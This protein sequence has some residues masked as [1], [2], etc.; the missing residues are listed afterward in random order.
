MKK[1]TFFNKNRKIFAFL[2]ISLLMITG[3][4]AWGQ[5]TIMSDACSSATTGWTFTNT[6]TT[7]AI[8]QNNY[9]LI[10]ASPSDVIISATI[11]VSNYSN[12]VLTCEVATYGTGNNNS[13]KIEYSLNNGTTWE[14]TS[15]TTATPSSSTYIG[16][17]NI[18]L[19]TLNTATLKLK[20]TNNGAT[21]QGV[22]MRNILLTGTS[23]CTTPSTVTLIDRGVTIDVLEQGVCTDAL[24][25]PSRPSPCVGWTFEGWK[26]GSALSSDV[27][28]R[29]DLKNGSYTPANNITLYAV[30]S[31]A[32][33]GNGTIILTPTSITNGGATLGNNAYGGGAERL[34]TQDDISF[35]GKAITNAPAGTN[36][37]T[38]QC[39][40][41]NGIIYNISAL[42]G[43]ILSITIDAT[44]GNWTCTGG[45][46][47][48][49]ANATANDYTQSGTTVGSAGLSWTFTGVNYTFFAI[50][51]TTT[52]SAYANSITI[53]YES[54]SYTYSTATDCVTCTTTPTLGGT[55]PSS[56]TVN[57]VTLSS[58]FTNTYD[59]TVTEYGF[60]YSKTAATPTIADTKKT[61]T[62]LSSGSFSATA[63]GLDCGTTYNVCSY[64]I[65]DTSDFAY[66][67]TGTFTTSACIYNVTLDPGTLGYVP[68]TSFPNTTIV[69]NLPTPTLPPTCSGWTFE[70]W[71]ESS[72]PINTTTAPT[73]L[74]L[75]GQSFTPTGQNTNITLYAVYSKTTGSN[76]TLTITR[77]NFEPG[78]LAYESTNNNDGDFWVATTTGGDVVT[79]YF[80]IY[81]TVNQTNMQTNTSRGT[82]P[83]N[84]FPLPGA[85][86]KITLTEGGTG[87][88]RAWTPYL[89]TTLLTKANY[90]TGTSQGVK[91]ASSNT[92]SSEWIVNANNR[93]T[94]FY[95]NMT[96]GAAYLNSIVIDY[97]SYTSY[98]TNTDCCTTTSAT[99]TAGTP[100]IDSENITW[101]WNI[102]E[103]AIGY[104]YSK[105]DDYSTATTTLNTFYKELGLPGNSQQKLYVWAYNNCGKSDSIILNAT[106]NCKTRT[107]TISPSVPSE[108]IVLNTI[109]KTY[110]R[111]ATTTGTGTIYWTIDNTNN[112]TATVRDSVPSDGSGGM[113]GIV[114]FD[115]YGPIVLTAHINADGEYCAA[116][117]KSYTINIVC[118]NDAFALTST[119]IEKPFN[120]GTFTR[121]V[122]NVH[123]SSP[124]TYSS[125]NNNIAI[126][127]ANTGVVTFVSAGTVTITASCAFSFPYCVKNISYDLTITCA[128]PTNYSLSNVNTSGATVS[129]TGTG[130]FLVEYKKSTEANYSTWATTSSNSVNFTGLDSGTTYDIRITQ[131]CGTGSSTELTSSFKTNSNVTLN[132]GSGYVEQT[133]YLNVSSVNLQIPDIDCG[134]WEFAGWATEEN[135]SNFVSN[136]YTPTG[137]ITLYAVYKKTEGD[138]FYDLVTSNSQIGEGIYLIGTLYNSAYW[139]FNGTINGNQEGTANADGACTS[140]A[141]NNTTLT[142]LPN[143][144]MEMLFVSTGTI[145]QYYVKNGSNYLGTASATNR[146]VTFGTA[147][148]TAWNVTYSTNL[149]MK[150]S[151]FT[152]WL[153]AYNGELRNYN[154]D[155]TNDD[156]VLFKKD[157]KTTT[158]YS[159][160]PCFTVLEGD[161][162]IEHE[163]I[164]NMYVNLK[165]AT[166]AQKVYTIEFALPVEGDLIN[167]LGAAFSCPTCVPQSNAPGIMFITPQSQYHTV[168]FTPPSVGNYSATLTLTA[169]DAD[170]FVIYF[171]GTAEE[172]STGC[173]TPQ[174]V[175]TIYTQGNTLVVN[176]LAGETI[177]VYNVLGQP[178]ARLTAQGSETRITVPSGI[179]LVRIADTTA[180]VVVK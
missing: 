68:Q 129:W 85:I 71:K 75:A 119:P 74:I 170:N 37:G 103:G 11:N 48:R 38:L 173:E 123:T 22:R 132:A 43:K 17:G 49:L 125:S 64:A 58:A 19:G 91:T 151:A 115:D 76:G 166:S 161:T 18:N 148:K 47:G 92:A 81:S 25:L 16:S 78:A 169:N 3:G 27:S 59:C 41:S 118:S 180:K 28:V 29:P 101:R 147:H 153:R 77:S 179:L 31:K 141:N 50:K 164:V 88:A 175:R 174:I 56:Q 15:F 124:I 143:G 112:P 136:T 99:P 46:T 84:D 69:N 54:V 10:D 142:G 171:V 120:E 140:S 128:A 42:K 149:S 178:L 138:I 53:N 93:F 172:V 90:T 73:G 83:Y 65:Y 33:V 162:K 12:L 9:W 30:Y 135:A 157:D 165:V 21:G 154:S 14:T 145:G 35:G 163:D 121:Q 111:K 95:L 102:V 2:I 20:F 126:V 110:F 44:G 87:T 152:T 177:E 79:G 96:G 116:A 113:V 80:D 127:D 114:T 55:T 57:S 176:T 98:S 144:A 117:D 62:N 139:F 66:G 4:K 156:I 133:E 159:T 1:L 36:Q 26:E 63:T 131:A 32:T 97:S 137:N 108:D 94:Y 8:Q 167:T 5:T 61:S 134:E 40:A 67:A 51:K 146:R 24:T 104:K 160:Y 100:I 106:T 45:N 158:T 7:N 23:T 109:P 107:I 72:A 105:T 82:F 130:S 70:G 150:N 89:S 52:G 122:N 6:N 86:T 60:V 168:V 39:Q 13:A 155:S 34:W